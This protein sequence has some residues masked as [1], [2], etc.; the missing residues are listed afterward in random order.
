MSNVIIINTQ[1]GRH[2]L[3]AIS[4]RLVLDE[5]TYEDAASCNQNLN[6]P[7]PCPNNRDEFWKEYISGK[8]LDDLLDKYYPPIVMRR[9]FKDKVRIFLKMILPTSLYLKK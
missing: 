3:E 2:I 8:T 1:K 6:S 7:Q 5:R 9:T 4:N